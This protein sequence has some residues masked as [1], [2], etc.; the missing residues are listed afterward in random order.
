MNATAQT[1]PQTATVP[2]REDERDATDRLSRVHGAAELQATLLALI[3]PPGSKRALH[4]WQIETRA[5]PFVDM[6][7][8]NVEG[9]SG[10]A[11]L[12]WFERMLER[13]A[14]QPLFIRQDL[15][16]AAR[17]VMAARGRARAIDRLHWLAMRRGCGETALPAAR[18]EAPHTDV[19]EWLESDVIDVALYTGFLSRMIPGDEADHA[20]GQGWYEAVM[21]HWQPFAEIPPWNPPPSTVMVEALHRLQTLS[22]VQRPSLVRNWVATAARMSPAGQLDDLAADALRLTC[23][24]LDSP[25]P[26]EL[27]GNYVVLADDDAS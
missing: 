22:W 6:L 24:L 4:A 5:M 8:G 21:A 11:R 1:E 9:L 15:L 2:S 23:G 3:L 16:K 13:I 26:P 25:Q 27:A 7:L 20:G 12:P 14:R 10:A 18:P 17:R 19:A